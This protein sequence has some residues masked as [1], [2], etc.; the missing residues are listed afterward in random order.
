MP[1]PT[2]R[3]L[4]CRHSAFVWTMKGALPQAPDGHQGDLEQATVLHGC[5]EEHDADPAQR[6]SARVRR[7]SQS[8]AQEPS[9]HVP[10]SENMFL[11]LLL[12]LT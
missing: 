5:R 8:R 1:N 4:W 2:A 3:R 10:V 9:A 7:S 11:L 12:N 6:R